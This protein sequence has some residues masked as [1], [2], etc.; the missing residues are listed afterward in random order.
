[1][2]NI[3]GA[4]KAVLISDVHYNRDTLEVADKC[5]NMAIDKANELAVPLVVCGDL[6]DTKANLRAEC[7]N[8]MIK[9]FERCQ[10]HIYFIVGNHD[11]VNEKS[12]DNA[13]NFLNLYG[14]VV[15]KPRRHDTLGYL[16]P[17]Y[18][19]VE[20]LKRF[21]QST[22]S[23]QYIMHQGIQGSNSGEYFHDHSA[24][25]PED[26]AG[27]RIISGHYHT[28]QTIDLPDG[29]KWD[30]VGNPY[31][32]N[33][34]ESS[35]P[36]KGFQVLYDDGS[37]EFVP[38][39]QRKHLKLEMNIPGLDVYVHTGD[40]PK[41]NDLVWIKLLCTREQQSTFTKE[42][43]AKK[44]GI[45]NF[46]LD[47]ITIDKAIAVDAIPTKV[48]E[49]LDKIIEQSSN[50]PERTLRLKSLWRQLNENT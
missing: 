8:R 45:Q 14:T 37:L 44:T 46:K 5:V 41:Q 3:R 32:L 47:Y 28:R 10:Y 6:H 42:F 9:T 11:L 27:R 17:Y 29:G 40:R 48:D 31:T 43:I 34:G 39:N 30:Y 26:V 7:V 33:F 2:S 13:L 19:D 36:E 4:V 22:D 21:L 38:T 49:Q 25:R 15:N 12:T 24:L 1:M 50:S 20:Q 23:H 16:V 35:D 18:S